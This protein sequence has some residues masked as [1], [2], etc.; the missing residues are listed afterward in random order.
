MC[1]RVT[2]LHRRCLYN[3]TETW[4]LNLSHVNSL[5]NVKSGFDLG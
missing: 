1:G 3:N 2:R 5:T 4:F